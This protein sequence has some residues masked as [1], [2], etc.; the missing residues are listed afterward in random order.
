MSHSRSRNLC[1]DIKL[2]TAMLWEQ[3]IICSSE[4]EENT[5]WPWNLDRLLSTCL[6]LAAALFHAFLV[7]T[8]NRIFCF[9]LQAEKFT[10]VCKSF[11]RKKTDSTYKETMKNVAVLTY[12]QVQKMSSS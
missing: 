1:S 10:G 3:M 11:N 6:E 5:E 8:G 4:V 9:L 7:T 12:L 2:T